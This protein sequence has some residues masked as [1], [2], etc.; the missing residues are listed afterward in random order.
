MSR[1]WPFQLPLARKSWFR[2]PAHVGRPTIDW[3]EYIGWT[4]TL[5]RQKAPGNDREVLIARIPLL[6]DWL[7]GIVHGQIRQ[8]APTIV[9]IILT[10]RGDFREQRYR[11]H[12]RS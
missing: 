6:L 10:L 12:R 7:P 4:N 9:I 1:S 8:Y 3:F 5:T 2:L 11:F